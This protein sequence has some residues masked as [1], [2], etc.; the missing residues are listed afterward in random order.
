[1]TVLSRHW[2][3]RDALVVAPELLNKVIRVSSG[4]VVVAG[5]IVETEAYLPDDPASH[6]FRG[7]SARNRT[8]FGPPGHLYVYLSYGIHRCANVVT[9]AE[10]SG[11]AVLIRAV[12][13]VAG[14][15]VARARRGTRDRELAN[16]PGKLCQAL[17]IELHD[18][19]CDLSGGSRITIADDD[20]PPPPEPVTGPRIGISKA[21]DRPWRFRVRADPPVPHDPAR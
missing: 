13:P 9:G 11:Q 6:S 12:V 19:G 15:E 7:P 1:M 14:I 18:D 21:V 5:R 8:M 20:V 4:D 10:G 16:G 17:G 2:F 3:E